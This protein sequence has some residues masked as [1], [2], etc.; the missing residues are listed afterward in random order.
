[1]SSGA[2]VRGSDKADVAQGYELLAKT[3]SDYTCIDGF[4]SASV[5]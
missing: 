5:R 4:V 3:I 1:M 2:K